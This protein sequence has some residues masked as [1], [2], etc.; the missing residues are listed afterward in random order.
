MA[1][2]IKKVLVLKFGYA[3]DATKNAQISISKAKEGLT[4]EQIKSAMQR[5]LAA[6]S[7]IKKDEAAPVD[8]IVEANYINTVTEELAL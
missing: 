4:P 3:M 7:L 5:V 1:E 2:T 6:N 8:K